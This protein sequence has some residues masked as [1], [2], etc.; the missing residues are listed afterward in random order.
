[1]KFLDL[2]KIY[3]LNKKIRNPQCFTF[4]KAKDRAPVTIGLCVKSAPGV[5]DSMGNKPVIK[6]RRTVHKRRIQYI[7]IIQ[8]Q[9]NFIFL[10]QGCNFCLFDDHISTQKGDTE[11]TTSVRKMRH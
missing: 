3:R 1:M 10:S 9:L 11:H 7:A 8:Q 5:W 4:G 2:I 6:L